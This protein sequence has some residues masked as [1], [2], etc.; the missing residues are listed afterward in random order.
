MTICWRCSTGATFR[1]LRAS[2]RLRENS[3]RSLH[4]WDPIEQFVYQEGD[5]FDLD[6]DACAAQ[7]GL[8]DMATECDECDE[9]GRFTA[10]YLVCELSMTEQRLKVC[11]CHA[12]TCILHAMY[13]AVL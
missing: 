13:T 6:Y 10:L 11:V 3:L 8:H 4:W 1:T 7:H 12:C 5:W 2:V 9:F